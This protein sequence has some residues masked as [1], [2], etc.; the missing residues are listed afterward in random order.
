M[1]ASR[2]KITVIVAGCLHGGLAVIRGLGQMP[3]DLHIIALKV[4][5]REFATASKY[6]NEVVNCPDPEDHD[7]QPFIE[8]LMQRG[9]Q[10][11][12]ALIIETTDAF[13][14]V[15]SRH[16]LQLQQF[17]TLAVPDWD[18]ARL[19]IEKSATHDLAKQCDVPQPGLFAPQS[20]TELDAII[21]QIV[22]PIMIKPVLSHEFVAHFG[23]KLFVVDDAA[24][25]R[26]QFQRTLDSQHAVMLQEII[27]GTDDGT[28]ESIEI[29]IDSAGNIGG[30]LFNIKLRQS[31]P[32]FGIMRVGRTVPPI[33]DIR[34]Y[35][36]RLLRACDYRGF[37]SA[38]FKRDP[39]DG[40]AKLIEV[41]VRQPRNGQMSLAS[42]INFPALVV[43]DLMIGKSVRAGDYT[44][45]YF[46]D[47]IPDLGNSLLREFKKT[48]NLPR[49]LRPYLA[50]HKTFAVFSLSDLGPFRSL[51]A[52]RLN[53]LRR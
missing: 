11:R 19:F 45:T 16:K 3:S 37:A 48:L 50:R 26:Q 35:T 34:D 20:M 17:Y 47:L 31:P 38:E 30:E 39:R 49:F 4:E 15:L 21:D 10:W 42:G 24:T 52:A 18:I 33:D 40:V 6:V 43:H 7:G 28:L 8:F 46:I 14:M 53:K 12:G 51:I 25:L 44:P 1:S 5:E 32:M 13:S 9:E 41:N 22:F 29:Y 36:H 23:E 27:P 2:Q